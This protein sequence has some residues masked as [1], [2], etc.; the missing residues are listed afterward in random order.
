MT[1]DIDIAID[2]GAHRE[3]I[4]PEQLLAFAR[5]VAMLPGL[6]IGGEFTLSG[7]IY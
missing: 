6:R 7:T 5:E 1:F 3:G 4:Q 2:F